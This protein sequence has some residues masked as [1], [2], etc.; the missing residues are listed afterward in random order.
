MIKKI[1]NN[2]DDDDD[3][4]TCNNNNNNNIKKKGSYLHFKI[5]IVL[6]IVKNKI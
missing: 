1:N 2:N 4:D 6:T 5:H 3:D